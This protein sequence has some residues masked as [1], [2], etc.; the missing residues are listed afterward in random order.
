MKNSDGYVQFFSF[1]AGEFLDEEWEEIA[2]AI[3]SKENKTLEFVLE[4]MQS[5]SE[6]RK[7]IGSP[8]PYQVY[9]SQSLAGRINSVVANKTV[10]ESVTPC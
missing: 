7:V 3:A 10:Q 5:E 6:F 2:Q 4:E 1:S 9:G 8:Y